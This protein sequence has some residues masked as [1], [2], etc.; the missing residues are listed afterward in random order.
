MRFILRLLINAA[1][2]HGVRCA[3]HHVH[4]RLAPLAWRSVRVLA[5]V[6]P[7]RFPDLLII[8]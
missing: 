2:L 7:R 6:R 5:F 8:F 3:W 1:A 4:G